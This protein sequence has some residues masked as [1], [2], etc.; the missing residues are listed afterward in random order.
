MDGFPLLLFLGAQVYLLSWGRETVGALDSYDS[1]W[2]A[3]KRL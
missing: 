3:H 2:F 1:R